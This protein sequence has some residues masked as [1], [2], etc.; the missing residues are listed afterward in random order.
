MRIAVVI[1]CYKAK[2]SIVSVIRRIGDEVCAIYVVDDCC[3]EHTA[4]F[5]EANAPD[6]R[7][8]IIRHGKNKGV[9]GAVISGYR[10][11]IA[12]GMDVLVKIDGDGQMDPGLVPDLVKPILR[13]ESD[14]VKGNRFYS[15]YD[16]R[17]M[18]A[19]RLVGNAALSF[20]TKISSGYWRIFDPTNGF[21]ALSAVAAKWINFDSIS[22]RFFFETDMLVQLGGIRAVVQDFPM[23]AMYGA[24]VSNLRVSDILFEFVVKHMKASIRRLVYQ[25]FLRDFSIASVNLAMGLVLEVFGITFGAIEWYRSVSTGITASTGTVMVAVLPIILGMQLLIA[26][27]AHDIGNEPTVPLVRMHQEGANRGTQT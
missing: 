12:D 7:L 13:L 2:S 15:L 27:L 24:E 21:T 18:P 6:P 22:N 17:K 16:V 4:D 19:M 26:F 14:Y 25:Y 8:K 11:A 3:P 10:Q 9:G 5:L 1:P 23:K 20:V